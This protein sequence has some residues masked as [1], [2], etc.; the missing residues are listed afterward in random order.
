MPKGIVGYEH[1]IHATSFEFNYILKG[2]I[3][4]MDG[5]EIVVLN[6][7]DSFSHHFLDRN[8][9]MRVRENAEV[10]SINTS[11]CFD[12]FMRKLKAALHL[13]WSSFR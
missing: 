2:S 10:L 5:D 11:P 7:G 8:I 6:P 9:M 3:E 1:T 4:L 13:C 12:M